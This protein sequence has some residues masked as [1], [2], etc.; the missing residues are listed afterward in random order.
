M[1]PEGEIIEFFLI[2]D[3]F[4]K[5]FDKTVEQNAITGGD[6]PKKR[7]YLYTDECNQYTQWGRAITTLNHL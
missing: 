7:K 1:F 6:S 4:S 2:C 3:D 5:V